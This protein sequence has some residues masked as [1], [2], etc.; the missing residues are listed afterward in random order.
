MFLSTGDEL[1]N[2]QHKNSIT[3]SRY[4]ISPKQKG[5]QH[6]TLR[7]FQFFIQITTNTGRYIVEEI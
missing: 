1:P 4:P 6:P 2:C 5:H 7:Q 3:E